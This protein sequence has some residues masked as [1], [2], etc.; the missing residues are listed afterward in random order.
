LKEEEEKFIRNINFLRK[1]MGRRAI[2]LT[3]G[4]D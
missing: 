4:P 2:K 3:F 1:E